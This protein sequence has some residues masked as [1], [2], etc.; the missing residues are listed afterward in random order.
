MR[1]SLDDRCDLGAEVPLDVGH[2]DL[3]VLDRIV[4]QG[5]GDRDLVE[6]DVGHDLR[7]RQRMV[8]V[9]LTTGAHL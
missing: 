2:G 1:S 5:G 7:N 3:G 9:A 4:Q 6:A 8:D